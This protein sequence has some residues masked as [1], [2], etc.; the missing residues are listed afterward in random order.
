MTLKLLPQ[1]TT[2]FFM[3]FNVKKNVYKKISGKQVIAEV[4]HIQ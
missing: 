1:R 2:K 4:C 3:F